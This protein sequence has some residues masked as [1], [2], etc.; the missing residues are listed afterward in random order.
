M[1]TPNTSLSPTKS[2]LHHYKQ[3]QYH[4]AFHIFAQNIPLHKDDACTRIAGV[5]AKKSGQV[6]NAFQCFDALARRTDDPDDWRN[7]A[8]TANE[9]GHNDIALDALSQCIK[10]ADP[11]TRIA[12]KILYAKILEKRDGLRAAITYLGHQMQ[13]ATTTTQAQLHQQ[14]GMFCLQYHDHDHAQGHLLFAIAN[15][16]KTIRCQA[17]SNLGCLFLDL[18]DI[19]RARDYLEQAYVLN[20]T[21]AAVIAN[22]C[23]VY[24]RTHQVK[25]GLVIAEKFLQEKPKNIVIASNVGFL[26][27]LDGDITNAT[28]N[29]ALERL[30]SDHS[31]RDL[32]APL[33]KGE[34][35]QNR[36][37]LLQ[38]EAGVG[39]IVMFA[40]LLPALL[41]RKVRVIL[42]VSPK[43]YPLFKRAFADYDAD[44]LVITDTCYGHESTLFT[45]YD[46]DCKYGLEMLA[47]HI[48]VYDQARIER[49]TY[50][51]ITPDADNVMHYRQQIAKAV[52]DD[53]VIGIS[54]ATNS[55][56][57]AKRNARTMP[58]LYWRALH[59]QLPHVKFVDLQFA[60][61]YDGF[62]GFARQMRDTL[63]FVEIAPLDHFDDLE[64]QLALIGALDLVVSIDNSNLHLAA[65]IGKSAWGILPYACD[66][67]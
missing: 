7:L 44:Q 64:Q 24:S 45:Q 20:P 5:C 65:A 34:D 28:Y 30:N 55:T 12:E 21:N 18:H 59:E 15:G 6:K 40:C 43:T 56:S 62:D 53:L 60:C 49:N 3:A 14:C 25:K 66:Y 50:P 17:M 63:P 37:I 42:S 9:I 27:F 1:N 11:N 54:W 31:F 41:A 57:L 48:P 2:L 39:D 46:I 61:G 35:L 67:R 36:C 58:A 32:P 23:V 38:A 4:E 26:Q 33:Y 19:F 52:G 10:G 16:T 22:L 8:V 51:S 47:T 29:I 13:D